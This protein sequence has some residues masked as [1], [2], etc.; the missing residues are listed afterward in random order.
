AL[1][2]A[3]G[4]AATGATTLAELR[5]GGGTPLGI[6]DGDVLT[7]SG[8][9]AD[10]TAFV[11]DYT[12]QDAAT[13]TLDDLRAFLQA[14]LGGGATVSIT[15]GVLT[16][17]ATQAGSSQLAGAVGPS[18]GATGSPVGGVDTAGEGRAG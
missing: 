11:A 12:V 1:Q 3:G 6:Q 13:E 10:G 4:N 2:D 9:R 18:N 15:G 5:R 7:F 14:Q 16:G 17:E 8:T